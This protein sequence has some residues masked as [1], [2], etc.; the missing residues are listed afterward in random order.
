MNA[1]QKIDPTTDAS[2]SDAKSSLAITV[3]DK[4]PR[5]AVAVRDTKKPPEVGA[6][7]A[8]LIATPK[9]VVTVPVERV[10]SEIS[11]LQKEHAQTIHALMEE[12]R[13]ARRR[14][15]AVSYDRTNRLFAEHQAH[16][17][18][19]WDSHAQRVCKQDRMDQLY[20]WYT[21]TLP[22]VVV[23]IGGTAALVAIF[24]HL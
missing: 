20:H 18:E 22:W 23:S 9:P 10:L 5:R 12:F 13:E 2:M 7:E 14:E 3:P 19:S 1:V 6:H 21:Q 16:I 4:K 17:T 11:T 8:T 15:M 24:Q